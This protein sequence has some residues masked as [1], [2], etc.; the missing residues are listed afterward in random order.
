M[1]KKKET[2]MNQARA[3]KQAKKNPIARGVRIL[4]QFKRG[5]WDR[6]KNLLHQRKVC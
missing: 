5:K 4:N 6:F 3:S 2:S 1:K